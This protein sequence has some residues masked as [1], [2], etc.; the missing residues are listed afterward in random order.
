MNKYRDKIKFE[1][2]QNYIDI[3][4][5]EVVESVV[6]R[7]HK[8]GKEPDYVKVYTQFVSD[9]GRFTNLTA[10]QQQVMKCLCLNMDYNNTVVIGKLTLPQWAVQ[11][12][13]A[14][15]TFLRVVAQLTKLN[16]LFK[17]AA[18]VYLVNPQYAGKGKWE[19]LKALEL[20]IKYNREGR[21]V[22]I[23]RITPTVI[24]V[25]EVNPALLKKSK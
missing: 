6:T 13:I 20:T 24:T 15:R 16:L 22:I 18:G 8:V 11:T 1:A 17:A 21:T 12:G 5:G 23:K 10:V 19:D 3:E 14:Q 4:T 2:Q 25:N 9:I 7:E